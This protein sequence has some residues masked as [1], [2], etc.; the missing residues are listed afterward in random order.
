MKLYR[1]NKQTSIKVIHH[2]NDEINLKK[3]EKYFF[4]FFEQKGCLTELLSAS[5]D[6]FVKHSEV[7]NQYFVVCN[8]L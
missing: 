7:K 5:I 1:I 6:S 8:N 2:C 3:I 4:E